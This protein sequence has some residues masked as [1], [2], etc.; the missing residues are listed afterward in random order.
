VEAVAAPTQVLV[1]EG[2]QQL[3]TIQVDQLM[4]VAVAEEVAVVRRPLEAQQEVMAVAV[5]LAVV[6]AVGLL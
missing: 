2:E 3:S 5:G 6:V 1:A 4:L